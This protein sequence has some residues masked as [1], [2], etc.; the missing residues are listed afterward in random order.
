MAFDKKPSTW[1]AS[2][3]E[4]GTNIT[5]PIASFPELTADEADGTTGDIRKVCFAWCKKLIAKWLATATADRPA[6][7]VISQSSSAPDAVTGII[8]QSFQFTFY[9]APTAVEVVDES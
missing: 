9:I 7:M 4:D 5:V 2:W 3:A 8:T 6:K 1:I